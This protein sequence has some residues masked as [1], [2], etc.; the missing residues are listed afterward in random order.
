MYFAITA[1]AKIACIAEVNYNNTT[2]TRN[3]PIFSLKSPQNYLQ[4]QYAGTG[5]R[6]AELL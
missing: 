5:D 1:T 3:I 4:T 2:T 6:G